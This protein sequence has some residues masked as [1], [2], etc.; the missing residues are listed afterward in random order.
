VLNNYLNINI[1]FKIISLTVCFFSLFYTVNIYSQTYYQQIELASNEILAFNYKTADSIIK[2]LEGEYDEDY[3]FTQLKTTYLWWM[4]I[5]GLDNKEM[6]DAYYI[7]AEST[8]LN[9]KEYSGPRRNCM[10]GLLFN[11]FISHGYRTRLLSMD[12]NYFSVINYASKTVKTI[13]KT[14]GKEQQCDCYKLTSGLYNYFAQTS[15]DESIMYYAALVFFPESNEQKGIRFLKDAATSS[16]SLISAE[17]AYFL[18]RIFDEKEDTFKD[19]LFYYNILTS[20]YPN[21]LIYNYYELKTLI[22]ANSSRDVLNKKF[23]KLQLSLESNDQLTNDQ[24]IYFDQL[25]KKLQKKI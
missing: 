1:K 23:Q 16:N 8:V 3:L 2:S 7:E 24:V 25:F 4:I 11:S 17:A 13:E 19:A 14:L 18:A 6:R 10:W 15:R 22:K 9:I 12:N 5:S 21:N 20:R